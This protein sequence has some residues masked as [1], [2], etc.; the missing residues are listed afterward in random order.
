LR[1]GL[2]A[3]GPTVADAFA[4]MYTFEATCMIQLGPRPAAS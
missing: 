3:V 4:A 2:L 1:H